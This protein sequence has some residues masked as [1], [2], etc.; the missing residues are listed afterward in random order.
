MCNFITWIL[1]VCAFPRWLS[2]KTHRPCAVKHG[3]AGIELK[4]S[5]IPG[6]LVPSTKWTISTPN[7]PEKNS[8]QIIKELWSQVTALFSLSINFKNALELNILLNILALKKGTARTVILVEQN[9]HCPVAKIFGCSTP[10][11]YCVW[12]DI[13]LVLWTNNTLHQTNLDLYLL[14]YM[15]WWIVKR[16]IFGK[17]QHWVLQLWWHV[18]VI[19]LLRSFYCWKWVIFSF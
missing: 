15:W 5:F 18:Y 2:A 11:H 7:D 9:T 16:F 17:R 4:Y 10:A 14:S 1:T 13:Y 6:C 12:K 3:A 8:G 19:Y